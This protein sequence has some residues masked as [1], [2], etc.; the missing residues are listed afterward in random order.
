MAIEL[1]FITGNA[2]KA[3]QVAK[4][5]DYPM[6]H[7]AL[8]LEEIQSL[9]LKTIVDHKAKQAFKTLNK[10]VLVEDVSLEIHALGRLPGPFIKWFIQEL[11]LTGVCKLLDNHKDRSATVRICYGLCENGNVQF[12]E[13]EVQGSISKEPKGSGWG[14]DN[15]F[16]PKSYTITR[17]QMDEATSTATSHRKAALKKLTAYLRAQ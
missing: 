17:G 11:D 13:A 16:T 5:I 2:N 6:T 4:W 8:D 14:F 9:D 10:P 1:T 7:H 3:A 15:I 12:F